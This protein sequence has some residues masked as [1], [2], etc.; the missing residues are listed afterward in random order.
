MDLYLPLPSRDA[1]DQH[2]SVDQQGRLRDGEFH[3]RGQ[4]EGRGNVGGGG[5]FRGA[6][7]SVEGRGADGVDHYGGF[8]GA[9]EEGE[10][11]C[12]RRRVS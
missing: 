7:T 1:Y 9:V 8:E 2:A 11:L 4:F 3:L 12:G 6:G 5:E 10:G